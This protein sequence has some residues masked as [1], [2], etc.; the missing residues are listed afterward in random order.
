MKKI[1]STDKAPAAV[2][3]YSQ[4]VLAN[5]ILFISGQLPLDPAT[6]MRCGGPITKQTRQVMENIGAILEE[7]GMDWS[8]VVKVSIF[9]DQ[10]LDFSA[11]NETY[12]EFFTENCPARSCFEVS[13]LPKGADIEIEVIA[14]K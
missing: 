1:I 11:V 14:V 9:L 3:P 5:G 12:A 8:H 6:G 10:M 7:A 4:A 2:G 13:N